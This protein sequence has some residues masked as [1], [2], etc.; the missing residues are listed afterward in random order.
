MPQQAKC[1]VCGSK[2]RVDNGRMV[3]H[4]NAQ[5]NPCTGSYN[6]VRPGAIE[7]TGAYDHLLGGSQVSDS[8][9]A[10][11]VQTD[12][13]VQ[14]MGTLDENAV[15]YPQKDDDPP[16]R[17]DGLPL[18][19]ADTPGTVLP[20]DADAPSV[21][22]TG[23]RV[24]EPMVHAV[25]DDRY[26]FVP[27]QIA[28]I[29][30]DPARYCGAFGDDDGYPG[31]ICLQPHGPH[32]HAW[33][34][35]LGPRTPDNRPGENPPV[36]AEV[37][38]ESEPETKDAEHAP[39]YW[40]EKHG[41][42][43][44]DADGWISPTSGLPPRDVAEAITEGEF[45]MRV[46]ESTVLPLGPPSQVH[47]N[48]DMTRNLLD[49]DQ[50]ESIDRRQVQRRKLRDE[51]DQPLPTG[52]NSQPDVQDLVIADI[53]ARREIGIQRYGQGLKT[54]NG[55]NTLRDL[56]EEQIDAVIYTRAL[57][58]AQAASRDR[59]IE[60]V[61]KVLNEEV[62]IDTGMQNM[63]PVARAVVDSIIDTLTEPT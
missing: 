30:L 47:E 58:E 32:E 36:L 57:L 50:G 43:I 46:A 51:N 48:G 22:V 59:L 49:P 7:E 39:P 37:P 27:D 41:L 54:F 19:P 29:M 60:V 40:A 3:S 2:E 18:Y 21:R 9:H 63:E 28:G 16:R 1:K 25:G 26:L 55:R 44:T 12:L 33:V 56:Y 52:D 11:S 24:S 6:V 61:A 14:V 38:P 15:P 53:H 45:L 13:G 34:K 10:A 23:M 4:L 35:Y 17:G 31:T 20:Q 42:L 62:E 8:A 5:K